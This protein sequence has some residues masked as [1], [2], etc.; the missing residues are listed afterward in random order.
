MLNLFLQWQNIRGPWKTRIAYQKEERNFI[1]FHPCCLFPFSFFFTGFLT[2]SSLIYL[3]NL[4]QFTLSFN[5]FVLFSILMF[6]PPLCLFIHFFL[7]F[8]NYSFHLSS[9][10]IFSFIFIFSFF[11][12][13]QLFPRIVLSAHS[14]IHLF[15]TNFWLL[16]F[17]HHFIQVAL[18]FLQ[19]ICLH[20]W[21]N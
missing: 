9:H 4:S 5:Y 3:N 19:Y 14:F 13:L 6:T 10:S 7:S 17:F 2:I 12:S 21:N 1:T 18:N 15:S 16:F 20:S 11:C 8:F